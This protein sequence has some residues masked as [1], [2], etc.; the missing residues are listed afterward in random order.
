MIKPRRQ[1]GSFHNETG[2]SLIE[3]TVVASTFL[4]MLVGI[5]SAGN[6]FYTHSA[7]AEATRRAARYAALT[8]SSATPG[9]IT[10]GTNIGPNL[11]AIR[12]IAIYGND[13]G[14]G[15]RLIHNLQ[16]NNVTVTY[17]Q[18]GVQ[19]GS[20][21]VII[22]NYTYPFVFPTQT[23]S[24]TMPAYRTTLSGESAGALPPTL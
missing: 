14:T 21:T 11:T 23:T 12:N 1:K 7:L 8:A 24:I 16:P 3:F 13:Q 22:E 9:T 4:L 15:P 2:G 18:F 19:N 5:V 17:N 10:T 20:V 6:L